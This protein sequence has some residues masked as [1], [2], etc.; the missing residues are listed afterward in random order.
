M[1]IREKPVDK[2]RFLGSIEFRKKDENLIKNL[3]ITYDYTNVL[4]ILTVESETVQSIP[5]SA[6]LK[7]VP[8]NARLMKI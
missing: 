8:T 6:L 1:T 2:K 7:F 3:H 5:I 4:I